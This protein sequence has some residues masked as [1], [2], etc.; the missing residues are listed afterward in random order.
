MRLQALRVTAVGV[1]DL[2]ATLA[3][4]GPEQITENREEPCRHVRPGLERVDIRH[5]PQQRFLYEI[6]GTVDIAAQGDCE[7]AQ[8]R[9]RCEHRIAHRWSHRHE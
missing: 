6:V 7:C 9:N 2:T 4:F 1:F 3:I 8:A 5:G